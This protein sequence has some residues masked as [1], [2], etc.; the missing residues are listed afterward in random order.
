MSTE[1]SGEGQKEE[2][3]GGEGETRSKEVLWH[4]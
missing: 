3:G 2:K 1:V 4:R